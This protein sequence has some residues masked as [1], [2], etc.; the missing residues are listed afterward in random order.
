MSRQAEAASRMCQTS[1]RSR[2][3]VFGGGRRARRRYGSKVR[4]SPGSAST[5]LVQARVQNFLVE[6]FAWLPRP[7][8]TSACS[9]TAWSIH[10]RFHAAAVGALA[11]TST[12][13]YQRDTPAWSSRCRRQPPSNTPVSRVGAVCRNVLS[14]HR[15]GTSTVF[16]S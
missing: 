12:G 3:I 6:A 2:R 15:G 16:G 4:S 9:A 14:N 10:P 1:S 8:T 5:L 11:L 7:S 13:T